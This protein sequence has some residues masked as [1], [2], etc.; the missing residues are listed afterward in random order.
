MTASVPAVGRLARPLGAWLGALGSAAV[1]TALACEV[2]HLLAAR[3]CRVR[4]DPDRP[5]ALVVLGCPSTRR[6]RLSAMQRW[7]VDVAVRS[8]RARPG[9]TSGAAQDGHD[10]PVD[11][12][13]AS[14][15]VFTGAARRPGRPEAEA[16]AAYG[17]RRGLPDQVVVLEDRSRSTFENIEHALAII[18]DA[19]QLAICSDPLH[20]CR[21]RRYVCRQRPELTARLVRADDYRPFEHPL[22]KVASVAYELPRIAW[23]RRRQLVPALPLHAGPGAQPASRR[24]ASA[25]RA[26]QV[27]R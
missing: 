13:A 26:G 22:L 6:G 2:A 19:E 14:R 16:M 18:G 11:V 27:V 23:I 7:R 1:L 20:A 10:D 4:I 17:R 5:V 21:G 8:L 15:V 25:R 3:T 24:G 12:D 9:G